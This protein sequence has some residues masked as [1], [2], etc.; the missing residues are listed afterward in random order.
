M[1]KAKGHQTFTSSSFSIEAK[2]D[3]SIKLRPNIL[4]L[5]SRFGLHSN[6]IFTVLLV[7]RFRLSGLCAAVDV[8]SKHDKGR[9]RERK[10]RVFSLADQK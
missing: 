4:F 2:I 9:Y 7:L 1:K 10:M 5:G 6:T 8:P 3:L